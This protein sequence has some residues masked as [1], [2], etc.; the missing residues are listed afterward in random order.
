MARITISFKS[1]EKDKRL[2]EY[3]DDLEDKSAEIKNILR[4][5]MERRENRKDIN[6]EK[7]ESKDH[8]NVDNILRF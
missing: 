2:F 4:R 1:T 5:E 3:W 8:E 7:T 6:N